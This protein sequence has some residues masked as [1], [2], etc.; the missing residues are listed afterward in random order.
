MEEQKTQEP[1]E[2]TSSCVAE[3]PKEA[4][5]EKIWSQQ[6]DISKEQPSRE[7]EFERYLEDLL[8]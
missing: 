7:Q 1:N 4:V 5:D 6:L 8:M 3:M 2:D